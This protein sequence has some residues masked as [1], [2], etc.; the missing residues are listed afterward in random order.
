[1][2]LKSM[3]GRARLARVLLKSKTVSLKG[4]VVDGKDIS[5][6]KNMMTTCDLIKMFT[7]GP[8]SLL[9][10]FIIRSVNKQPDGI[11]SL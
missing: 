8:V 11:L 5:L 9:K 4:C 6:E 7:H 10:M 2:W 3:E 1:M